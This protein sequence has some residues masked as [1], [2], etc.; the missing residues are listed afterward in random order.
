MKKTGQWN[1]ATLLGILL[2]TLCSLFL[3]FVGRNFFFHYQSVGFFL[4]VAT[5]LL[6]LY[7]TSRIHTIQQENERQQ[8]WFRTVADQS[9]AWEYWIDSVGRLNT[10]RRPVNEYP[11]I[12]PKPSCRIRIC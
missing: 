1:I 9:Y 8:R 12:P 4:V 10:S 3:L 7:A 5:M 2:V 11:A 6:S